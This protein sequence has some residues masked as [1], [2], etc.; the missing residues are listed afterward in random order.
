MW[1]MGFYILRFFLMFMYDV[2]GLELFEICNFDWFGIL[3]LVF[4]DIIY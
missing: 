3:I 2:I 4:F 1:F